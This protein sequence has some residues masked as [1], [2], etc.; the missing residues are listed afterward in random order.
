MTLKEELYYVKD[1]AFRLKV[2][3]EVYMKQRIFRLYGKIPPKNTPLT[4]ETGDTFLDRV[5]KSTKFQL[6]KS[7]TKIYF[8][9]IIS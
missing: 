1:S 3:T 2:P 4:I 8:V 7:K 6:T 9:H 5:L